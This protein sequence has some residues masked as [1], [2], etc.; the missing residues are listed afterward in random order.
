MK[1][2]SE[3]RLLSAIIFKDITPMIWKHEPL[4][5]RAMWELDAILRAVWTVYDE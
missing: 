5:L 2:K 3:P 1:V 4:S